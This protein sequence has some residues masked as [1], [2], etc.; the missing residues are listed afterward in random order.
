MKLST[1]LIAA[2]ALLLPASASADWQPVSPQM[3]P[4]PMMRSPQA[5]RGN[6]IGIVNRFQGMETTGEA[7]IARIDLAT[8]VLNPLYRSPIF[9]PYVG[10]DYLMQTNLLRNGEIICPYVSDSDEGYSVTWD[11][12]DLE[13][14]SRNHTKRF[15]ANLFA[16]AYSMTYNPDKD[17]IYIIALDGDTDGQFSVADPSNDFNITYIGNLR[18]KAGFIAAIAYNMADGQLYAFNDNNDVFTLDP[19]TGN[20]VEAG[21]LELPTG[22]LLFSEGV[23]GQVTYSPA[24]GM[25]ICIFRDN[26]LQASRVLY[27]HPETFEVFEGAVL[28]AE[29]VPY[30]TSIFCT[31]EYA[32]PE[33]PELPALPIV[34]FD[35]PSLSGSLTI[36]APSYTYAGDALGSAK[37]RMVI[38][39]DGDEVFNREMDPGT[40]L[41]LPL[42]LRE[43]EHAMVLAAYLGNA[44]S[45]ERRFS[46]YTGH[47]N[48]KA[49]T[50]LRLSG[51]SLSWDAVPAVG[52]H[53]GHVDTS[54]VTYN[55]YLDGVLQNP[56]P[57]TA[58]TLSLNVPADFRR[59]TITVTASANSHTSPEAT[60]ST[61]FGEAFPLPFHND[62]STDQANLYN[63]FNLNGDERAWFYTQPNS[64]PDS[65]FDP[66]LFGWCFATG[67]IRQADDWLLLPPVEITDPSMLHNFSFNL[68]GI[69]TVPTTESFEVWIGQNPTPAG[70]L[71]E[72]ICILSNPHY[73]ATVD[74]E[75]FSLN[76]GVPEA[77]PW[78]VAFH[79]MGSAMT[80]SQ[81]ILINNIDIRS[82][83]V[84]A[85]VPAD[86]T[87]VK[88][89]PAPL[90]EKRILLS[91][92]MPSV[93]VAGRPLPASLPLTMKFAEGDS[94][95][96]VKG[97]PGETVSASL[98]VT[99]SGFHYP[100][101]TPSSAN[102]EGYTRYYTLYAG[103]DRPLTPV[104]LRLEPSADNLS[105]HISWD[106]PDN[107]GEN[108]GYV[109]TDNLTYRIYA[110]TDSNAAMLMGET[111]DC[112]FTVAPFSESQPPLSAYTF[113]A[114]AA[115]EGGESYNTIY[116]M[117]QLGTPYELPMMEEW[118]SFDYGPYKVETTGSYAGS[119]WEAVNSMNGMG[120]GDPTMIQGGLIA[121]ATD[122]SR[123][124]AML[125]LPKATTKGIAKVN[126]IL[127][128]WDYSG[129]PA[130]ICVYGRRFGAPELKQ[131]AVFKTERGQGKWVDGTVVLPAGF[132]DCPW[133]EVRVGCRLTGASDEYLVLDS[134]QFISDAERDLKLTSLTAPDAT[135]LGETITCRTSVANSGKVELGGAVSISIVGADGTVYASDRTEFQ[136]LASNRSFDFETEFPIDGSMRGIE[137]L[138][139][140][141]AVDCDDEDLANNT[142]SIPLLVSSGTLPVVNDLSGAID[143]KNVKLNWSQPPTEYGN[144]ETFEEFEPFWVTD[145]FGQWLNYDLDGLRPAMLGNSNTGQIIEWPGSTEPQGWTIVDIEEIGFINEPRL[146]P[147]SGKKVLMARSGDYPDDENPVQ[148]SKWLISPEVKGGTELSFWM[149]TLAPDIMEYIEVWYSTTDTTLDPDNATST[150]NGSFRRLRTF[151]KEGAETWELIKCSLPSDTKHFAIR[152]CSYDST[153]VVIDDISFTPAEMLSREIAY[154]AVYRS[155]NGGDFNRIGGDLKS[156]GFTDTTWPDSQAC[157]YVT[158]AGVTDT[159]PVE[160]APSNRIVVKG[161]NPGDVED[162]QAEGMIITEPGRIILRGLEG[163]TYSVVTTDG[164]IMS[165]GRIAAPSLSI[166]LSPGHYIVS[167]GE[168]TRSLIL[169]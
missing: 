66:S 16:N 75:S 54:A 77:G 61:L 60:L 168:L 158:V 155:D 4:A 110:R 11:F 156:P 128:Y 164:R 71:T 98:A 6:L 104:N 151:S 12:V 38:T 19:A 157:Y 116:E 34:D 134:F 84:E 126:F 20:L 120:I 45:P 40:T 135:V 14:G 96:E 127:R 78:Y 152:Y 62:P 32:L 10:E 83:G 125:S 73:K 138:T 136:P 97:L 42:T 23:S 55:V 101:L 24:D 35:G 53:G 2:T 88:V 122:G 130:E 119:N 79:A 8:G 18:T 72:G 22:E 70:M 37:V 161:S 64:D 87:D 1:S 90:G 25:F 93:D 46:I 144:F 69:F 29:K 85:V 68:C 7:Y 154:Y 105:I 80:E 33:A 58:T 52:D 112:E 81:G 159:N 86:P 89:N 100:A 50:G 82:A 59:R 109:D 103:L 114:A 28:T 123:P 139:I 146:A 142:R 41:N 30:V 140:V 31:D 107:V 115:N 26:S 169:R 124:Q 147:H 67:Y 150:R 143:G 39:A 106:A 36:Q 149:S 3:K 165:A 56:S 145:G 121:F 47:D 21:Y 91:A 9:S 167:A 153:A 113:G 27:I 141:A 5:P 163:E 13:S 137:G 131:L 162:I 44:R 99:Q 132:T 94:E 17:L 166:A 74:L 48:P 43:G 92:V 63:V 49:P 160:G 108:G 57:L 129:A 95:V 51:N 65:P 111:T 118:G 117:E 133:I 148:S 76:F 15:G 102:G